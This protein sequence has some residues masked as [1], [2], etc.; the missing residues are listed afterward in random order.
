MNGLPCYIEANPRTVEPGNAA[1]SGVDLPALTIAIS[2][3][4]TLP[5]RTIVGRA[6]IRT[7]SALAL[8]L[9]AAET[10]GSRRSAFAALAAGLTGRGPLRG[11]R[12]V[13][14]PLP[15]DPLAIIPLIFV[16]SQVLAQPGRARA[17]AAAAV[18]DYSVSPGAVDAVRP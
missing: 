8:M 10:T 11:S 12:E 17:L 1:A 2:R 18:Q 3:G 15:A 5:A 7:H 6:G 16:A 4:D 13:L 14:T 9:G